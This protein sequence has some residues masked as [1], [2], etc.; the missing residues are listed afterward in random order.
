MLEFHTLVILL[1][2][3]GNSTGLTCQLWGGYLYILREVPK[4]SL[5]EVL[6]LGD[7]MVPEDL[8]A[9]LLMVLVVLV[10]LVGLVDFLL[11]ALEGLVALHLVVS[12]ALEVYL[13]VALEGL[14]VCLLVVLVVLVVP[15][16]LVVLAALVVLLLEA[17]VVL[18][19][20]IPEINP[21]RADFPLVIRHNNLSFS[22][23][24]VLLVIICHINITS[25]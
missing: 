11:M 21:L 1:R 17:L 25:M 7:L 16:I 14:V 22:P 5:M 18:A 4:D 6:P 19:V 2:H 10:V 24:M 8:A 3:G 15:V 13:L 12:E 9:F 20:P 23:L